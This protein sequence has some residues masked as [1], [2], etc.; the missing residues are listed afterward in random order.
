MLQNLIEFKNFFSNISSTSRLKKDNKA[1]FL[2]ELR[3]INITYTINSCE[4]KDLRTVVIDLYSKLRVLHQ[5]LELPSNIFRKI[6]AVTDRI[7]ELQQVTPNSKD[8]T[9][10]IHKA[11]VALCNLDKLLG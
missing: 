7:T 5:D 10:A 4:T 8:E 6:N 2:T 3:T 11:V 1:K 9:I